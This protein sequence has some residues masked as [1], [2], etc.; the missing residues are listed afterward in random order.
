MWLL[1]GHD[2]LRKMLA[3]EKQ[4]INKLQTVQD[5]DSE[6]VF[7]MRAREALEQLPRRKTGVKCPYEF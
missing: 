2:K 5:R 1:P 4:R 7:V 3:Q 6:I